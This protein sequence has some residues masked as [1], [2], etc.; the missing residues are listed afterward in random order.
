MNTEQRKRI[1][2]G[3]AMTA[4]ICGSSL[5][6]GAIAIMAEELASYEEEEVSQALKRVMREHRGRLSLAAIIECLDN[7]HG[8]EAA[9]ELAVR[10][11]I[12]DEDV[13]LVIPTA[14][15]QSWPYALL[16]CRRQGGISHGVQGGLPR[17]LG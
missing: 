1:A 7:G 3:L 15:M 14:I 2:R 11:R 9:W 13:T 10:S 17:A 4:E 16:E 8:V 6:E 12:W 5:S